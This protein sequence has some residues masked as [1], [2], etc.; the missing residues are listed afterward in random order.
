MVVREK[1]LH[2]MLHTGIAATI[3]QWIQSFFNDCIALVQLF[4]VFSP[5]RPFT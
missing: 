3:I 5:S 4:N 1:L 2:H